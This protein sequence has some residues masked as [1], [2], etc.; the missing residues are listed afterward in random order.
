M[1][2]IEIVV[3][4]YCDKSHQKD[5]YSLPRGWISMYGRVREVFCSP[6]CLRSWAIDKLPE[7][8]PEALVSQT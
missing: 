1:P 4:G 2:E 8:H 3:C 5:S 6:A 7:A